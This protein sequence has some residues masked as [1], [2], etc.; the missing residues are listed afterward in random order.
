MK[1]DLVTATAVDEPSAKKQSTDRFADWE[2]DAS[3]VTPNTL[4][5]EM[6][7]YLS[8]RLPDNPDPDSVL[9][10]WKFNKERY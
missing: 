10:W 1:F 4:D 6:A 2:D 9:E 8:S 3:F 7:E 5:D